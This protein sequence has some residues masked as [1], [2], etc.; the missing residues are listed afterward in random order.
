MIT[1]LDDYFGH[2]TIEP[3]AHVSTNDKSFADRAYHTLSDPDR[4]GIDI[5]VS[6]Y[7]N[8][9]LFHTYAIAAVPG[10]QWSL[11]ATRDFSE[12]RFKLGAGP[13]TATIIEPQQRWTYTCEPNESG[14]AFD[15]EFEARNG[16]YQI[17]QPPIRHNGRLIHQDVYVFQTGF[18]SGTVTLDDQTFEVDRVPGARDRTWGL[19]AAGE[20]QLPSGVLGWLNANFDDVAIVAH[21][22]DGASG[23]PQVRGGA[24]YH[25]GGDIIPV[26][27]FEHDL[28]FDFETRQFVSGTVTLTDA[29]GEVWP[30]EIDPTMR[31]YLSGAGYSGGD[32]RR[33][34]F[35]APLWHERWDL[36]DPDLVARV[37][38]LN[39]NI[40]HLRCNG[41]TGHGVLETSIGKHDRYKVRAPVEWA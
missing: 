25:D 14:I 41:R 23:K 3:I 40:S 15:L 9:G 11:R 10:R 34:R 21:I 30:V 6:M 7:P 4:F 17:D 28:Q 29:T 36:T 5:G 1:E 37:E 2:Q 35:N 32:M 19:R 12:G 33:D 26:V 20:G 38:G 24:I 27:G 18:Y 31:I 8:R 13:I 22:R 16:P 39:D